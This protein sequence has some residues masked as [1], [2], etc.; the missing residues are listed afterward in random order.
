MKNFEYGESFFNTKELTMYARRYLAVLPNDVD[1]LLVRGSSGVTIGVAM[2]CLSDRPL[3]L[4]CVRKRNESRHCGSYAGKINKGKYVIVDDFISS[5][6]TISAILEWVNL[7]GVEL[8]KIIVLSNMQF[9]NTDNIFPC[10]VIEVG[11]RR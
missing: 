9:D 5:G 4:V 3:H 2:M 6:E 7:F 10:P 11:R 8:S 1:N